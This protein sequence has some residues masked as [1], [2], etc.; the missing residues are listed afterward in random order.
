M[1]HIYR[2][3]HIYTYKHPISHF[4]RLYVVDIV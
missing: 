4:V 2:D 1:L 3:T